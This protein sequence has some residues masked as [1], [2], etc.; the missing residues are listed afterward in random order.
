MSLCRVCGFESCDVGSLCIICAAV[1]T[2]E[3]DE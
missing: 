1:R 2:L 3:G